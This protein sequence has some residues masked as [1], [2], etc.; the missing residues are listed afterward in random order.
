MSKTI[1]PVV[2]Q[3]LVDATNAEL[4]RAFISN[5]IPAAN[6]VQAMCAPT[7]SRVIC[8]PPVMDTDNDW[9]VFVPEDVLDFAQEF[10]AKLDATYSEDQA[11]Y[12]DGIVYWL[13]DLN[14]ILLFDYPTFYRWVAATYYARLAGLNSK[15][16]RKD[17][18][19]ALIDMRPPIESLM[20]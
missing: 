5:D 14:I 11:H 16:A 10:L 20:L 2:I 3:Q 1:P 15:Q 18:F 8:T 19:G 13:G 12:P 4:T 6:L 7:G 9:L 17:F